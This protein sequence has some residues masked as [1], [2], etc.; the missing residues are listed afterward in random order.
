[1]NMILCILIFAKYSLKM[2]KYSN[3][4]HECQCGTISDPEG[5]VHLMKMS[6]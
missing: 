6:P 4:W 3:I 1:M 5:G 2:K